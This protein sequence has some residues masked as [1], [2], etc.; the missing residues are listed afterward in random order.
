MVMFQTTNQKSIVFRG[1]LPPPSTTQLDSAPHITWQGG[2]GLVVD[3]RGRPKGRGLC[4]EHR[5]PKSL[6]SSLV[7]GARTILKNDMIVG[8]IVVSAGS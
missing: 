8:L 5:P 6:D 4:S 2:H 3:L 1:S 7:G